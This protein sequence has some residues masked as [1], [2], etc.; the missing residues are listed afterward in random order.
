MEENKKLKLFSD[1]YLPIEIIKYVSKEYNNVE[2]I[3]TIE[4]AKKLALEKAREELNSQI[5]DSENILNEQYVT[6]EDAGYVEVE[7]TYEVQES[8]GSKEK[9]VF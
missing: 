8:I 2:V 6:Y 7:L 4:E 1:F 5:K 9:I 3:H